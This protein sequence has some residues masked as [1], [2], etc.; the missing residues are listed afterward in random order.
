VAVSFRLR[1]GPVAQVSRFRGPPPDPTQPG[2][3]L[4]GAFFYPWFPE[5]W[6]QAGFDPFTRYSPSLGFYDSGDVPVLRR[7]VDA[8]LYGKIGLGISSWWGQGTPT[9][10]RVRA[11][12]AVARATPFRWAVYYEDEGYSD[13]PV[14]RLRAD[15][16]YVRDAYGSAPAYLRLG[17]RFVVFVY[18]GAESCSTVTR[19]REANTVGAFLVLKVFPGFREC[20]AQPDGWHQYFPVMDELSQD[21]YAF[22]ISPGFYRIDEEPRLARDL[23]RWRRDVRDMVASGAPFQLVTTFNEWGEGTSVESADQWSTQ[24]SYGAYLDALHDDGAEPPR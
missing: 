11:E 10:R 12:L 22:E 6:D 14:E 7:Q 8:M 4:R 3:P 1:P 18:G 19:W 9:D 13:P 20:A 16:E 24:S 23:D 5:A 17:G 21:G 15:L 2:L